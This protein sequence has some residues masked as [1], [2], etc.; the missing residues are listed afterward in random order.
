VVSWSGRSEAF[1]L[2]T[3]TVN[4]VDNPLRFPGQYEGDSYHYNMHRDYRPS[5]GRYLQTD[6]VGLYDGTNLFS[7]VEAAPGASIDPLG[8]FTTV[9]RCI[10]QHGP[11]KCGLGPKP[12]PNPVRPPSPRPTPVPPPPAPVMPQLR[13]PGYCSRA[14]H[15]ALQA[16]VEMWCNKQRRCTQFDSCNLNQYKI[17][18]NSA[19]IAARR[20]INNLCFRGG[21]RGHQTALNNA[22]NALGKCFE[23]R[24]TCCKDEPMPW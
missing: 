10:Q 7:Y 16:N 3:A 24:P 23:V 4:I 17:A 9:D 8:L 11:E 13:P 19:C 22:K 5:I 1:G 2:T 21:D 14:V 20:L 18:A 12:S 15:A 6:P